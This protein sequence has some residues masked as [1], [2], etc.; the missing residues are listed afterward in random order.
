MKN[1]P[2]DWNGDHIHTNFKDMYTYLR[3]KGYYIE[4]LG[5]CCSR[6]IGYVFIAVELLCM[7]VRMYMSIDVAVMIESMHEK[8]IVFI[9]TVQYTSFIHM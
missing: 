6:G 9:K 4:V 1:D 8:N 3:S 5:K 2:L 7:Y